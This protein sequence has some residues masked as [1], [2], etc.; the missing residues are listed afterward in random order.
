MEQRQRKCTRRYKIYR[1]ITNRRRKNK[2]SRNRQ[3]RYRA[4]RILFMGKSSNRKNRKGRM[5]WTICNKRPYN[6]NINDNRK[7][8]R[9]RI[10]GKWKNTK[11][12]YKKYKNTK[13]ITRTQCKWRK[14]LGC[15][16]KSRWKIFS[17]VWRN[18]R[19]KIWSNNSRRRRSSSKYRF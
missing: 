6:I 2:E 17:M 18:S 3:Y 14:L 9:I 19:W 7:S 13:F 16:T 15:I 4:R 8:I 10:S 1:S 11:K 12:K 5:L